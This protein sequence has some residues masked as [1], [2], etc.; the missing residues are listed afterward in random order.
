MRILR[1]PG[2]CPWDREQTLLSLRPFVI[3]EA[4][5]VLEAI[6]R[7]DHDGLRDELGDLVFETVF[8]AQLCAEAGRFTIADALDSVGDKLIRRHPHVFQPDP[9]PVAT[10]TVV[11][12]RW[13]AIK[14]REQE[15]TGKP[16]RLLGGIPTSLPGLL[17][18]DRIGRRTATVGFDWQRPGDVMK[19]VEEELAEVK[20]AVDGGRQEKIVEEIGD[21]LFAVANLARHVRVEPEDALRNAN[22]KFSERLFL[23]EDRF[24]AKGVALRDASPEE[25]E[26]E[27]EQIKS[28]D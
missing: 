15:I 21:L 10:S 11:K 25:M 19:K 12:E 26:R 9:E 23:L 17:Y 16:A 3:E 24:R 4:Y 5:E 27:W 18:A 28:G 8:L 6:D 7:N 22:R 20:A 14:A 2:G 1:S 13:E